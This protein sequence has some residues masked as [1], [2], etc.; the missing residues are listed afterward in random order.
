MDIINK[1]SMRL[2]LKF[3]ELINDT[4]KFSILFVEDHD[5]LRENTREILNKFF[6]NAHSAR[7]GEE[8]LKQY[9]D[10]YAQESKYYDIVLSD[11]QMPKL[12]GVELVEQIYTLNPNQTIIMLSAHDDAKYLIPLINLKIEQFIKKPIDYQDLLSAL[13]KTTK[14]LLFNGDAQNQLTPSS[15]V[16]LHKTCTFD[17]ETHILEIDN[18]IVPLTKYEILFLQILTNNVG[19]IYSNKEIKAFYVASHEK[20][21][22][23]NIRKLVSKLRKKLSNNCIESVYGIGYRV[24]P[25]SKN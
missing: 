3:K 9:R 7:N 19:K 10:F 14:K 25:F 23:L 22:M 20:L 1:N 15:L 12:G 13:Q 17:K 5:E 6:E 18:T 2:S 11:I 16:K 24:I 8:A 4:K 21:D